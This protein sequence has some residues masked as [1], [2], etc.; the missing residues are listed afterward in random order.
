MKILDRIALTLF[1]VIILIIAILGSLVIFGWFDVD[2]TV[3][4][5]MVNKALSND[6]ARNVILGV[7]IVSIILA[8][9]A[10]FFG[11]SEKSEKYSD[12]IILENDD[13]RLI[14]TKET[15][16]GIINGVVNDFDSIKSC[17]TKIFLDEENNLSVI[18]NIET[19]DNTIIKELINNLQIKIKEKLKES[20]DLE[21]KSLD[22]RV[23]SIV[24]TKEEVKE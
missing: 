16:I 6:T 10:I 8:L 11:S 21:V 20:L 24:E 9:K 18:L 3:V 23:K 12:S 17:Q 22:V 15:L 2:T 5:T 7:N 19:T 4:Y 1:S 14:I 13:G